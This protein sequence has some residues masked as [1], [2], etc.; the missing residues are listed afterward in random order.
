MAAT[1]ILSVFIPGAG[2]M[3]TGA[4]GAGIGVLILVP[5]LL[6]WLIT[7]LTFGIGGIIGI[8]L[9]IGYVTVETDWID[10]KMREDK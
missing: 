4:A 7:A 10:K 6:G 8:P 5:Y 9:M 1:V 2:H 3:Y